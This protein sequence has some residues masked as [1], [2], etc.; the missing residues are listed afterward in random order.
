M[1]LKA[2]FFS[3]Q[4]TKSQDLLTEIYKKNTQIGSEMFLSILPPTQG[5]SWLNIFT[6]LDNFSTSPDDAFIRAVVRSRA[7]DYFLLIPSW[8]IVKPHF[9]HWVASFLFF[10]LIMHARPKLLKPRLWGSQTICIIHAQ[11]N[12]F[13]C[14]VY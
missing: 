4:Y 14:T 13:G 5:L 10:D 9:P 12:C 1:P 3:I 6:L 11:Q 7:V 2:S 8:A